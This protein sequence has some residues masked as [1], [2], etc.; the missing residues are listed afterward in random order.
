MNKSHIVQNFDDLATSTLRHDALTI[1]ESGLRAVETRQVIESQVQLDGGTLHVSGHE[2][3]LNAYERVYLFGIGK[4]AADAC[5]V[6]EEKLGERLEGGIVLDVR[7]VPLKKLRS[8]VG[9][10]PL[11]SEKNV[12]V[13]ED[14][15]EMLDQATENDLVL[16]VISGGGSALMCLPNDMACEALAEITQILIESGA[17]IQ[18]INIV[19]KHLSKIQ[20]GWF[21]QRAYPAKV[22]SLI[23]SDVPGDDIATIASGP[24]VRDTSTRQDA[25]H[26]LNRYDVFELCTLP[27]CEVAETPKEMRYFKGVDNILVCTNKTALH[28]MSLQAKSMG[29][30][31]HMQSAS[32]QGEARII[33]GQMLTEQIEPHSCYLF[34][35]ETTV[36]VHNE[37]GKGGR[38]QEVALGSLLS[39]KND[40]VVVASASDG[41]DNSDVAGA[42]A[43][44]TTLQ[45]AQELGLDVEDYLE[46]NMSYDFF[47][48]TGDALKTGRLGSNV[49]DLYIVLSA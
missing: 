49:S 18:E 37:N 25:K 24:T 29:Y 35:G 15:A 42:L 21:A 36:R 33:G 44:T 38:N 22:V 3:D 43:D 13:T 48:Q 8:E 23:F 26:V 7:G 34:G 45:K 9:T 32:V 40:V 30:D 5:S 11:P 12:A 6:L 27:H 10:H 39:T 1:L 14:I 2:Y 20:G 17:T 31:V 47:Q 28:A 41:W 19:R 46:R 16:T 4:C